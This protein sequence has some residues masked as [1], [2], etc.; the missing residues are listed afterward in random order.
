MGAVSIEVM[1]EKIMEI[2]YGRH[3]RASVAPQEQHLDT[4]DVRRGG[5]GGGVPV[6]GV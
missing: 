6:V 2:D 5:G 3:L 1:A 4:D